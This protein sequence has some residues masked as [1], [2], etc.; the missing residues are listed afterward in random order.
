MVDTIESNK[1]AYGKTSLIMSMQ[2]NCIISRICLCAY[3]KIRSNTVIEEIEEIAHVNR[4]NLCTSENLLQGQCIA[5]QLKSGMSCV[6]CNMS[7]GTEKA[8]DGMITCVECGNSS[9]LEW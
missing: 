7:I 1:L 4:N 5:V 3:L 9:L 2:E 6:I 8:H